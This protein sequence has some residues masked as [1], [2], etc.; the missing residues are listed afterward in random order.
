MVNVHEPAA[1]GVT[2]NEVALAVAIVAI[3]LHEPLAPAAAVVAVKLVLP[4]AVTLCALLAPLAVND[5][6]AGESVTLAA[7]GATG[8]TGTFG[9]T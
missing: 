2:V 1:T 6:L 9:T 8:A 5:K 7:T 3:P 4:L